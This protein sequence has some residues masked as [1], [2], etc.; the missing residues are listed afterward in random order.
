[1]FT[2]VHYLAHRAYFLEHRKTENNDFETFLQR[3]SSDF[4]FRKKKQT[5]LNDFRNPL[6][7]LKSPFLIVSGLITDIV[8][9]HTFL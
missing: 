5:L 4:F 3:K 7:S 2:G 1:M 9:N 8:L 6:E